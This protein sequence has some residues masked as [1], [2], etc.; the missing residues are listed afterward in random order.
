MTMWQEE[1]WAEFEEITKLNEQFS[2]ARSI[3][4]NSM[5]LV[6]PLHFISWKKT[7]NDAVT[8]RRQ[9]QFTPKM[10]ANAVL[11][12]L[13]SLVWIYQ[14]N[15]CNGITSF[16]EFMYYNIFKQTYKIA[17]GKIHTILTTLEWGHLQRHSMSLLRC[18]LFTQGKN[19]PRVL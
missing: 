4:M 16:M 14:D 8:P 12:L 7:Q 5:K 18:P 3:H 17:T 11:H 13:S 1:F 9:S 2:F 6:I 15:K 19:C 10:T